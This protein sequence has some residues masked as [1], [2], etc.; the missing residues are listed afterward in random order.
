MVFKGF[1]WIFRNVV[2]LSALIFSKLWSRESCFVDELCKFEDLQMRCEKKDVLC[3]KVGAD[4]VLCE[5]LANGRI[6]SQ[7]QEAQSV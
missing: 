7:I 2:K 3:L 6:F 5:G 1:S 4:C